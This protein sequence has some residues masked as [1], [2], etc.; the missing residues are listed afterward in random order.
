MSWRFCP[1]WQVADMSAW[2][3]TQ[4]IGAHDVLARVG[5]AGDGAV[6]VFLGTVRNHN[7]GRAVSGMFYDAYPEMAERVLAEI[8]NEAASLP[9]VSRVAAVHRTGELRVGD[10]SVAIAAS[11]PHRAQAFEATRY[12]IEQIKQR[13]PVWKQERYLDGE[14]SWLRGES[15]AARAG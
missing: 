5:G 12:V 2:I 15:E 13:L 14:K 1:R 6:D 9:G 8:V 11:A 4:P 10:V 7:D 3:T